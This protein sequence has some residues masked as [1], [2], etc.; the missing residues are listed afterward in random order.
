MCGGDIGSANLLSK[1]CEKI[2]FVAGPDSGEFAGH[3]L[4]IIKAFNGLK[5]SGTHDHDYWADEMHIQ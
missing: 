4:I 1:T 2:A 3:T 5:S